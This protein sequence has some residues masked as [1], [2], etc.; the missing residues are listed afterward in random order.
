MREVL[1]A[2]EQV[3]NDKTAKVVLIETKKQLKADAARC[4][5]K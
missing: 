3:I 1:K 2:C 4:G 5:A